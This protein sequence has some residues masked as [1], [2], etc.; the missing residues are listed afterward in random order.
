VG[1]GLKRRLTES[2]RLKS[3]YRRAL[4]VIDRCRRGYGFSASAHNYRGQ[5]WLRDLYYSLPSLIALGRIE[6]VLSQV[7]LTL[8]MVK[9]D[10][11][12]PDYVALQFTDSLGARHL[13]GFLLDHPY[14]PWVADTP[15]LLLIALRGALRP[16]LP[17]LSLSRLRLV[18][19]RVDRLRNP[20]TGLIKGSDYKD[21][22]LFDRYLLSNQV[23]L[24]VAL[25]LSG[26]VSEAE[27]VR[28]AIEELYWDEKL[29]Y[30]RDTPQGSRFDVLAHVKLIDCGVVNGRRA[31]L[32]AKSIVKASTPHGIVNL[33]PPY[34]AVEVKG[35]WAACQE[36][37]KVNWR[38]RILFSYGVWRNARGGYQNGTIWPFVHNLAVKALL[39]LGYER[40]AL[41][42]FVKLRGF[43][44]YYDPYTG[45]GMGSGE[46]LWS[47]ATWVDAYESLVDAGLL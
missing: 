39:H 42:N 38:L 44:E 2:A 22:L 5:L 30:Y 20:Y 14:R 34:A 11:G 29:G 45:K 37:F 15:L 19:E 28:Q 33:Y 43:H 13:V 46:Q 24:Y 41:E 23:D 16:R 12:V 31:E 1:V 18:E 40:E 4:E 21:S 26:R 47:A 7:Q 32:V 6:E 35:S 8:G 27:R 25:K 9:D 3:M 36:T 17:S 10:G